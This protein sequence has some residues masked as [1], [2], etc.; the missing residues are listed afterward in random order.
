L[1]AE[2]EGA[3]FFRKGGQHSPKNKESYPR[4]S[5]FKLCDS[6][7]YVMWS[8]LFKSF[9]DFKLRIRSLKSCTLWA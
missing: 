1:A 2:D 6:S 5:Y 7:M 4:K 8:I 9:G 3:L